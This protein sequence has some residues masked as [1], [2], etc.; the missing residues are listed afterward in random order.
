[1]TRAILIITLLVCA[2]ATSDTLE[3]GVFQIHYSPVDRAIAENSLAVLQQCAHRVSDRLVLGNEPI[4]V[5]IASTVAEFKQRAGS[6][7]V[8][9]VGGIAKSEE[10][11]IVIKAPHIQTRAGSYEGILRHELIHVLLARNLNYAN[12][13][14]WLNEGL[15]M[16]L[17]EEL[18]WMSAYRV[19]Q[20]YATGQ[21]LSYHELMLS[22]SAFPGEQPFGDTYAQ[23]LSMTRFLL[24][25]MG[26]DDFWAMID[27]LNDMSFRNAL[28]KHTDWIP[29][30]FWEE[31]YSSLWSGAIVFSLISGF[32]LFQFAAILLIIGYVRKRRKGQRIMNKW[33]E[34]ED[35]PLAPWEVFNEEPYSWE[36]EEDDIR[37]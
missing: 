15:A 11:V 29:L 6:Y 31:W 25:E 3:D 5:Y 10:G 32:S 7:A 36:E 18:R 22:F 1:M 37:L 26:E 13:P 14:R 4:D 28:E 34:D 2:T 24:D 33:E 12:L 20:M 16:H 19:A 30:T 21:I 9:D 27:D 35:E 17:A 23:S 8:T